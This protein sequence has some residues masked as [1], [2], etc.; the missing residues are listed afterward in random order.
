M[1]C[2]A[3]IRAIFAELGIAT[4]L[5]EARRLPLCAEAAALE[6]AEIGEDG[7]EY[8]LTPP[9]AAAWRRMRDAARADGVTLQIASA[10]RSVERQAEIVR[11]KLARG[12]SLAT[13]LSASAPPGYSEHH[14]GQAIDVTTSGVAAFEPEFASTAAYRWLAGNAARFGFVL[15]FPP[16]NRYGYQY[17]PWHWY[18]TAGQGGRTMRAYLW[19]SGLVFGAV[20]L[21]HILRLAYGWQVQLS[22]WTVPLALS[23]AGVIVAGALC[24]WA[25]ALTRRVSAP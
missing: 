19:I 12:M 5:V 22:G 17:E 23:W 9:A 25:F 7:R 6:V 24:A 3:R 14:T 21:L 15:S 4:D 11:D 18:Y 8:R 16:G 2:P 20:T 13:I 1:E 10:F